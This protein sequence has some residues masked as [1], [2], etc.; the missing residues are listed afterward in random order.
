[1]KRVLVTGASGE[2][3]LKVIE[4]LLNK[5]DYRVR[6]FS[7]PDR[8]SR[9]RLKPF[10]KQIEVAWGDVT[11]KNQIQKAVKNCQVVIHLAAILPPVADD[12]PKVARRVNVEGTKNLLDALEKEKY[13]GFFLYASSVAIYG[14]RLN[15]HW[16]RVT[17][18]L[19]PSESDI[20][21]QTKI[22]AEELIRQSE[23][24][25]TIF[26][27]SAIMSENRKLDPLFFHMPLD[28]QIEVTSTRD[29]AYAMVQALAHQEE[30]ANRTFNLGGGPCCRATYREFLRENFER[31]GIDFSLVPEKAFAEQ[32][33]HCGYYAD[34]NEL[35]SILH[36]QRDCIRDLYLRMEQ[37]V[38]PPQR[39]FSRMFQRVIV[40]ELVRRSAP[41]KARKTM[42]SV[43]AKRFFKSVV[44]KDSK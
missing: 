9:R 18:P 25:W 42:A 44:K 22:D 38:L 13:K 20:Y 7:L 19:I 35:E 41:W 43:A 15:H 12:E 40:L 1:M 10:S 37:N 33:F 28:T 16:I 30:L 24:N 4:M 8:F 32:N 2:I 23:V 3:G 26:R 31:M 6:V 27:L 14:D 34:S 11:Q 39:F 36:F 5:T 21:A 29:T 17:D